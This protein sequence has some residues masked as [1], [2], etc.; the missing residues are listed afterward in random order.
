MVGTLTLVFGGPHRSLTIL[1]R[2]ISGSMMFSLFFSTTNPYELSK[3]LERLKIPQRIAYIPALTISLIPRTAKDATDTF[4]TLLFRNEIQGSFFR[5]IP[6]TIAILIATAL[7]RSNFIAQSLYIK[8]F[9]LK[10]RKIIITKSIEKFE[11]IKL[12]YWIFI[13]IFFIILNFKVKF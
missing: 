12:V 11:L 2:L 7:Y 8:N 3:S 9:G 6:K 1:I 4:E 5:W 10:S 13:S